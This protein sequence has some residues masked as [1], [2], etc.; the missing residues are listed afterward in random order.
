MAGI[1]SYLK[2]NKRT[3]FICFLI[4]LFFSACRKDRL[5]PEGL[6]KIET[7]TATDRLNKILFLNDSVGFVAGGNRFYNAAILKTTDGGESWSYQSFTDEN[8][9]IY[10]ITVAPGNRIY[11]IGWMGVLNI[12]DDEGASWQK[13]RTRYEEY[14]DLAF[15]N[16]S[17]GVAVGGIS[18][19]TGYIMHINKDG[20]V[21]NRDSLTH[22]LND[23]ENVD[24]ET[25]YICGYGVVYKT[26][27]SM[28]TWQ[29]LD[30]KNDNFTA[31][32]A[33]ADNEVWTCGYNGSIFHSKDGGAHW[34]KK[35]NGNDVTKSRYRLL[36]I[37]FADALHGYAV[38]EKGLVVYTDDGGMH[39]MEYQSFTNVHLRSIFIKKDGTVFICGD[40]GAVFKMQPR[41]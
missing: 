33:Y 30:V 41:Q 24:G 39:W 37:A 27:D 14:K 8:N 4:F 34:E 6:E 22:E 1:I 26:T 19:I 2:M 9:G 16:E 23:I 15:T 12:S 3:C 25:A 5:H 38:G 28:K 20:E 29:L 7:Y 36:D 13:K 11:T 31:V 32:H 40:E 17:H 21:L 10:G 18:F 35:R